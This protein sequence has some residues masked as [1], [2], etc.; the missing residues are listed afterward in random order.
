[1][2]LNN[3]LEKTFLFGSDLLWHVTAFLL[4]GAQTNGLDF[5]R[6]TVQTTSAITNAHA[7]ALL[8]QV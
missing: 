5:Q 3:V 7:Q 8:Q 6:Q 4:P 1:M 2:E